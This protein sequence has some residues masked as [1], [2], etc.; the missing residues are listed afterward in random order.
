MARERNNRQE[1]ENNSFVRRIINSVKGI[2]NRVTSLFG[3]N[4]RTVNEAS[5]VPQ[6]RQAA[7]INNQARANQQARSNE[8]NRSSERVIESRDN[9][10]NINNEAVS[11]SKEKRESKV[12][13]RAQASQQVT[14]NR[15]S[16]PT[17]P[18]LPENKVVVNKNKVPVQE[19]SKE[20]KQENKKNPIPTPP[21]L[22][23]NEVVGNKN[24][25]PVQETSKDQKQVVENKKV[26]PPAPPSLPEIDKKVGQPAIG[27]RADLMAEIRQNKGKK[28][29]LSKDH[30]NSQ[31]DVD[32]KYVQT[33]ILQG[34]ESRAQDNGIFAALGQ[35]IGD[36]SPIA[37]LLNGKTQQEK[38]DILYSA[39]IDKN[40]ELVSTL[41]KQ[42]EYRDSGVIDDWG[43][44]EKTLQNIFS[45]K[46][47]ARIDKAV[48]ETEAR[49][50]RG[51]DLPKKNNEVEIEEIIKDKLEVAKNNSKQKKEAIIAETNSKENKSEQL[52]ENIERAN[53]LPPAPPPLS[54][55]NPP[56]TNKLN[57]EDLSAAIKA[58]ATLKSTPKQTSLDIDGFT[59]LGGA[60]ETAKSNNPLASTL[61]NRRQAFDDDFSSQFEQM[62]AK[63]Q[64]NNLYTA[65][66]DGN[67]QKVN[68]I[69]DAGSEHLE[70][71]KTLRRVCEAA[72]K[73]AVKMEPTRQNKAREA[74]RHLAKEENIELKKPANK[75]KSANLSR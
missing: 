67:K 44:S 28:T 40:T 14:N 53:N 3:R 62:S 68:N 37:D 42:Q 64:R 59:Y 1:Q 35:K 73:A 51:E 52:A 66:L 19:T 69:L 47:L 57:N 2:F 32:F 18:P 50:S 36:Q 29:N 49:L 16:I 26:S 54:E 39:T 33:D 9:N 72:Q 30:A 8:R 23:E 60:Q 74:I 43:D 75:Q 45:E 15:S 20:Q 41:K 34:K 65:L 12:N 70:G 55:N 48:A 13:D 11:S 56:L 7:T 25:A 6:N 31:G 61:N 38:L 71:E 5:E 46:D 4:N 17:P 22:P 27:G 24:K 58:G 21:P 63:E 10:L